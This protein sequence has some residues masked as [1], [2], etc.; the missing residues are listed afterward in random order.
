MYRAD[1]TKFNYILDNEPHWGIYHVGRTYYITVGE[2]IG[3]YPRKVDWN[4]K[5]E[6]GLQEGAY[7]F[8]I[9][10][11]ATNAGSQSKEIIVYYDITP[12]GGWK[13]FTPSDWTT[14]RT[15]DCTIEV[16]D[17]LSGLDVSTAY[18]KFSIN[19]GSSWSSWIEA[20]D[21]TGDDGTTDYETITEFS[22]PFNHDS[23]P[24]DKCQIRFKI[25]DMAGNTNESPAYIVKID[26]EDPPKPIISS[27][28]HP[29]E[30]EWYC[31]RSPIFTWTTP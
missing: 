10:A 18:Y 3:G 17:T 21:C 28:T 1:G 30:G 6:S 22:V 23:D 8:N 29:D 9:E 13:N 16:N 7:I 12:P 20:D 2:I 4:L 25:S 15:P 24:I 5:A 14:D 19:S 31:D 11:D 26:S 27:S